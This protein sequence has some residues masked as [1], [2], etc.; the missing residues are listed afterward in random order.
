[1]LIKKS[2]NKEAIDLNRYQLLCGGCNTLK[3][4]CPELY[5]QRLEQERLRVATGGLPLH[6]GANLE[7]DRRLL[8]TDTEEAVV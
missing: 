4:W 3:Q 1:L 6:P 7:A 5:Q 8:W 2:A